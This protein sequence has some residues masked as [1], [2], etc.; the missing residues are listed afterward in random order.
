MNS[1]MKIL[2]LLIPG[3]VAAWDLQASSTG[4]VTRR[5]E[6][7][8]C[9]SMTLHLTSTEFLTEFQKVFIM[10]DGSSPSTTSTQSGQPLVNYIQ[11]LMAGIGIT[12]VIAEEALE[13]TVCQEE[14]LHV[15]MLATLG[16]L[17]SVPTGAAPTQGVGGLGVVVV[18]SF[19][20]KL[21]VVRPYESLRSTFLETLLVISI[22]AIIRLSMVRTIQVGDSTP[23]V[24]K[25]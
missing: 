24:A 23:P 7:E 6:S 2:L 1:S 5:S 10:S 17:I 15:Y 14:L 22:V 13:M 21:S 20:G 3:F 8:T 9:R 25:P 19:T 11:S 12:T 16:N 4:S 18:D